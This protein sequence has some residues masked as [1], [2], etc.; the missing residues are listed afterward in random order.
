MGKSWKD[1]AIDGT[2]EIMRP[3]I[4]ATATTIAAF[5]PLILLPGIIGK[6]LSIVPI[7]VT[8]ALLASMIEAFIILP[9]H[10]ADW[11]GRKISL[12]RTT[13]RSPGRKAPF[14]IST[15]PR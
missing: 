13:T 7:T 1:A 6:F 12:P 14:T 9:C 8:L 5:L 10:F 15:L 4:S 2:E 3:V 11:P